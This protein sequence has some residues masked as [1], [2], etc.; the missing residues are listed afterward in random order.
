MKIYIDE[1]MPPQL[2]ES[3]N[4]LQIALNAKNGSNIQVVSITKEFGRGV[5]DEDWIPLA[6]QE[7]SIV[8]T[9][10]YR[11]QTTR[12]QRDLFQ[13]HGLGMF[14]ISAPKKGMSF[15]EMTKL[16]INRWEDILKIIRKN[17]TPFAF[18]CTQKKPFE[19][20]NDG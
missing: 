8:I 6:G 12:H 13:K 9:Q 15:W 10:D 14:F 16:L 18:R 5:K 7:K 17:K 19:S 3:L 1:N 4:I 2:A 20:I 11:I